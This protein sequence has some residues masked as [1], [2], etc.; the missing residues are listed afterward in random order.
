M[1]INSILPFNGK[2]N[3]GPIYEAPPSSTK[4]DG[5][6]VIVDV[7][8]SMKG[9]STELRLAFSALCSLSQIEDK[10]SLPEPS[11]STNLVGMVRSVVEKP[12]FG[13]QEI[14]V[15]TDGLDNNTEVND[16]QVGVKDNGEP[17]MVH[18]NRNDYR[19]TEYNLKRQ[20]A[21]LRYLEFIGANVHLVGIGNEVKELLP[22]AA[23]KRMTVA[24]VPSGA[25]PTEVVTVIDA[26]M[27]TVRDTTVGVQDFSNAEEHATASKARII[28]VDN[29]C[30]HPTA[31]EERVKDVEHNAHLVYIGNDAL[32]LEEFKEAFRKAE[33]AAQIAECAKKYTRGV[34][35]WLLKLS[36]SDG[37]IPGAVIG[38]K[39]AKVF[40]PPQGAGEWKVNKLLSELKKVGVV[41]ANKEETVQFNVG[42]I[43]RTFHKVECYEAAPRVVSVV[44]QAAADNEW[45]T[46]QDELVH[47][48]KF[49]GNK[50]T[51][52]GA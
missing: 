39:I 9:N 28:T 40:E 32:T 4:D 18:V 2:T 46:L 34:V 52:D 11:G 36:L 45:A 26:A 30:G 20:E 14:I 7:S 16:F 3:L 38:G 37:K 35:M 25:T 13:R 51:R 19:E 12:T 17:D 6:I 23:S 27:K 5:K 49:A 21:I 31:P 15:V 10:L 44:D 33:D 47:K 8:G 50:R 22:M 43:S 42:G 48:T 41:A 24:H 29:L 1:H